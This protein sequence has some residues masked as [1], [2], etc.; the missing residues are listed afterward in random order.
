[1]KI[2]FSLLLFFSAENIIA[3]DFSPLDYDYSTLPALLSYQARDHTSLDYRY[4]PSSSKTLMIMLHGSAYHS[5][6]LHKFAHR[7]S[8]A[9]HAQMIVPDLRG[10][11]VQPLRR[12]DVDY[13]GQLDDDLDDLVQFCVTTY[14]PEK[15]IIAGHSS[16]GSLALRLMGSDSRR[17][18]DGYIMLAPYLAHDAPTTN[19]SSGWATP[20]LT[21][22]ILAKVL[23]SLGFH[24]LDHRTTVTFN[25]PETYRDET[26][27]L[28][29]SHA[30]M[31]SYTSADYARD[32]AH[33][34]KKTLVLVG[35][36]DEAMHAEAFASVIPRGGFFDLRVLPHI[37]HIGIV[38][39]DVSTQIIGDWLGD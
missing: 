37:T 6:Y 33:T 18:V 24:W 26:E 30:L 17:Q 21:T 38:I 5:R 15:I 28:A 34:K 7:L 8:S 22:I 23:N 29:Y 32:L 3:I 27:T 36:Q 25:L 1:M 12:G 11:G 20:T 10:H 13:V 19:Q 31:T 35:A 16:G 9:N 39:D 4:Y 14:R 2:L